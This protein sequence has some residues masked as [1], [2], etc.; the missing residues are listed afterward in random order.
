MNTFTPINPHDHFFR[1]TFDVVANTHA[2]LS[3]KLPADVLRQ[4]RLES[5]Q[6]AKETFL[7]PG[8]Q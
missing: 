1:R 4:I 5:L 2:L 6:P 8:E 3:H 7:N